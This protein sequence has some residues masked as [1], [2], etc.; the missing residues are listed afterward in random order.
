MPNKMSK[1]KKQYIQYGKGKSVRGKK[2]LSY[3]KRKNTIVKNPRTVITMELF[4]N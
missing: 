1:T 2:R 3:Q 4:G